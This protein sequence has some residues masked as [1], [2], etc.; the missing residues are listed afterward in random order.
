[1]T[2]VISDDLPEFA[3]I[4]NMFGNTSGIFHYLRKGL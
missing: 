4:P 3:K 2:D 1:M